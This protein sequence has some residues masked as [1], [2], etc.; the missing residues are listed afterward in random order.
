MNEFQLFKK[1]VSLLYKKTMKM[2][3][4]RLRVTK[5]II[6]PSC[7][8]RLMLKK[9]IQEGASSGTILK[10]L[11]GEVYGIVEVQKYY[12]TTV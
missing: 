6:I 2:L 5:K 10:N 4:I 12:V 8:V 11:L 1:N 7:M 9:A 3:C